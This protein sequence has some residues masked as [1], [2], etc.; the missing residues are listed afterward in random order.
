MSAVTANSLFS[1]RLGVALVLALLAHGL[2][3]LGISFVPPDTSPPAPEHT[4][5]I[6]VVR[7][8]VPD[9]KP[10]KAEL[11]AQASQQGGGESEA[12]ERITAPPTRPTLAPE[13]VRRV[14]QQAQA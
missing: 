7:N 11:L 2:V 9:K 13:P 14:Q 12:S 5:D 3:L 10:E 1:D 4:L 8:P 6:V